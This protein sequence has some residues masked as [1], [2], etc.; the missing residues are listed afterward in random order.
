MSRGHAASYAIVIAALA[1]RLGLAL[2]LPNDESDD[3]RLYALIARNVVAHAVYSASENAP[4]RPTYIRVP[5]Y[6]LFLAAMYR[7]FGDANNTAVRIVQACLDTGTCC[8]VALLAGAWAPRAWSVAA[9]R[10]ITRLGLV[11]AAACP[12]PAIFVATI[13]TET[14]AMFLGTLAV[15]LTT[16][17]LQ[18]VRQP[19]GQPPARERPL[20]P[21]RPVAAVRDSTTEPTAPSFKAMSPCSPPAAVVVEGTL[22]SDT[23][24]TM[25]GIPSPF[26]RR[27]GGWGLIGAVGGAT[28]LVRPETL[29]YSVAAGAGI[30]LAAAEGLPQGR[31]A[32]AQAWVHRATAPI[33]GLA[34]GVL[35]VLTPWTIRNL[36]TFGELQ[37]LNPRSVSMPDEFVAYGY[38]RWV[39]TWIDHP[40]YVP[41]ALFTVDLA[42]IRME[43]LPASAFDSEAERSRVAALLAQYNTPPP[44]ADPDENG[45]LPPG[46]MTP[47]IDAGF[48]Q[49]ARERIRAHPFRYYVSLPVRRAL[50][51]WFDTHSDFYPFAGFVFP[52]SAWDPELQQQVWLPLFAC[53]VGAWT[54]AAWSGAWQLARH[55]DTRLWLA[56]VALL[57]LP[58][59]VL[60]AGLENPEPRYTV[61]FFPFVSALA[62][63]GVGGGRHSAWTR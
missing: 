63:I 16:R 10:R 55:R 26:I 21:G 32:K 17:A 19:R 48:A 45:Q 11:L 29:L 7:A 49:L 46:G 18:D 34:L 44:D 3:G 53:L 42:P 22:A 33:L 40:R 14:L 59:L 23:V 9:R 20:A 52:T 5:G 6:P 47:A 31:H 2:A 27:L 56:L 8:L 51:L 28:A 12:F 50:T 54:I 61:E 30:L 62:A 37:P 60:L 25:N 41:P 58:R 57:V 13:L 36:R 4:Y 35:V 39:R 1:F 38:A 43:Q 24:P 15:L